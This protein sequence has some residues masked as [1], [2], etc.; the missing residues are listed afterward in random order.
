MPTL[1][2]G[3]APLGPGLV[4]T[5]IRSSPA[6]A[7]SATA[8]DS[9][10]EASSMMSSSQSV[11]VWA[12]TDLM[13][14]AMNRSALCIGMTTDTKGAAL[15]GSAPHRGVLAGGDLV[16]LRGWHVLPEQHE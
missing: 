13:D 7:R 3:P 14:C 12:S 5:Q 16:E 4:S 8:R 11:T 6:A 10:C 2:V 1:R 9:S 15:T